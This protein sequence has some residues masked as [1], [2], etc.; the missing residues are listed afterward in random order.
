[1]PQI[2]AGFARSRYAGE[3]HGEPDPEGHLCIRHFPYIRRNPAR[4]SGFS[5]SGGFSS[6]PPV[7]GAGRSPHPRHAGALT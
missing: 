6:R 4:A 5:Y 3:G 2:R 1:M 7:R